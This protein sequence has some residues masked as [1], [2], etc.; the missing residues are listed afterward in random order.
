MNRAQRVLRTAFAETP[1]PTRKVE[2]MLE[3][4]VIA[5]NVAPFMRLFQI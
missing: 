4:N 3:S 2:L 1:K 5:A